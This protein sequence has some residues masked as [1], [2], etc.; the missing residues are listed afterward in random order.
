[1]PDA[2]GH[3]D[4]DEIELGRVLAALAD[5][6]RRGVVTTLARA[7]EGTERSCGSFN[8]AVAKSTRTHHFR[9]LRDA[10]LI[11]TTDL[12]NQTVVRLRREDIEVRLPGLLELLLR[13]EGDAAS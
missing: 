10:G 3:P 2:D 7:P 9:V 1:M 8:L 5:A 6:R 13:E 4:R 12:G 11:W